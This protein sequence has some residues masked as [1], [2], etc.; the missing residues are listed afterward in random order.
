MFESF[1]R[2]LYYPLQRKITCLVRDLKALTKQV[3]EIEAIEG[4]EGPQGPQGIQGIQGIQGLTGP[5]GPIGLT[6]P[7]GDPG[8]QGI[9]GIQGVQGTP[10]TNGTNGTNG[11]IGPKGDPGEDGEDG[12][13][14]MVGNSED[15]SISVYI[16]TDH[17]IA[18]GSS[19]FWGEINVM[20]HDTDNPFQYK[21]GKILIGGA[22]LRDGANAIALD[23]GNAVATKLGTVVSL[24]VTVYVDSEFRL[25]FLIEAANNMEANIRLAD[26]YLFSHGAMG[27][28]G[29]TTESKV[30]SIGTQ[31]PTGYEDI[32]TAIFTQLMPYV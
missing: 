28:T 1:L 9:Q 16:T 26:I 12:N 4:P 29:D 6:G 32:A 17:I 25:C 14:K 20:E 2:E 10:G 8:D 27:F 19:Q 21:L 30:I 22:L 7:K 3:S 13:L 24:P 31:V 18:P 5:Q 23:K 15:G 11:A